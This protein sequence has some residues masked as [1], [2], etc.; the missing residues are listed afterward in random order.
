MNMQ[1]EISFPD[2]VFAQEVDGE[3]VL[4]DMNSENYF[5]LDE[6]GTVMWQT[7]Q[8]KAVLTDVLQHLLE[9]YDVEEDV[10]GKDLLHFVEKLEEIGLL[11]V[12]EV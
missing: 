2:T 4:L 5:G 12:K 3:T 10:L 11:E 7:L 8:E 6:V 1:K 9:V